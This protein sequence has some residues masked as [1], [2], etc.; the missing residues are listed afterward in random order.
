MKENLDSYLDLNNIANGALANKIQEEWQKLL[1]NMQDP[2]AP[3]KPARKLVIE[4]KCIQDEKRSNMTVVGTVNAKLASQTGVLAT[5]GQGMDLETGKAYAQEYTTVDARQI[6]FRDVD[7]DELQTVDGY[8][9]DSE[10]EI[11][12]KDQET[13]V[14]DLRKAR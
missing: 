10:G 8:L 5:Y 7:H 1:D 9:V 6:S 11:V 13:A 3:F 2:N 4:L 14:V 12:S